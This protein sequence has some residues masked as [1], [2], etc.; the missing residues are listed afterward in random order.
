MSLT[1]LTVTYRNGKILAAYF[2]LPRK[3]G[4]LAARSKKAER[5]LVVDFS[6]DGRPIGIEITSP[7][8]F[9]V[10]AL[11]RVLSSLHL[12]PVAPS[13]MSPLVGA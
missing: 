8:Q 1:E 4:D 10:A 12:S 7:S 5:G 13:V 9:N 2:P 3:S 6:A 11:N